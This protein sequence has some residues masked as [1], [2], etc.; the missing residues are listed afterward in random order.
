MIRLIDIE[1]FIGDICSDFSSFWSDR[2]ITDD[3]TSRKRERHYFSFID[4]IPQGFYIV[5]T[6]SVDLRDDISLHYSRSFSE[7]AGEW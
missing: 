1:I 3:A 2:D 4:S 7:T 6:P 5:Y